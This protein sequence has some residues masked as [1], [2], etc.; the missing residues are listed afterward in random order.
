MR[1]ETLK[2][3]YRLCP[4]K[5][6]ELVKEERVQE[7]GENNYGSAFGGGGPPSLFNQSPWGFGGRP[8]NNL[9]SPSD[10]FGRQGGD[11]FGRQGGDPFARMADEFARMEQM[12]NGM[13]GAPP[14]GFRLPAPGQQPQRPPP[15]W[16]EA[17]PRAAGERPPRVDDPLRGVRVHEA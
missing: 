4:N 2:R 10:P 14:P 13:F 17:Q 9:P 5:V 15:G 1:C 11:P 8:S 7:D 6:P 3:L 12:M 16:H